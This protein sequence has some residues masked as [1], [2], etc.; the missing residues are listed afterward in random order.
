MSAPEIE[1]AIVIISNSK[2]IKGPSYGADLIALLKDYASRDWILF[3]GSMSE[4]MYGKSYSGLLSTRIRINI[5]KRDEIGT[6]AYIVAHEAVHR[7]IKDHQTIDGELECRTFDANFLQELQGGIGYL[8]PSTGEFERVNISAS[9]YIDEMVLTIDAEKAQT[10]IDRILNI[11]VYQK[12]LTARWIDA[13]QKKWGGL[14]RR[15]ENTLALYLRTLAN[16]G[17]GFYGPVIVNILEA[18]T[19]KGYSWVPIK[20][21]IGDIKNLRHALRHIYHAPESGP[22]LKRFEMHLSEKFR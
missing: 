14:T 12:L 17:S 22:K 21:S 18:I 6:V 11:D 15:S 4:N 16:D 5:K 19:V 8:S 9:Q 7:V 10:Q 3:D 2:T 1:D 20:T 13:N